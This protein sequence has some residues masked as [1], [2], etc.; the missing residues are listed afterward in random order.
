MFI[1]LYS[2]A[3]LYNKSSEGVNRFCC[4]SS[5][6]GRNPPSKASA[7]D[8]L[9]PW[10]AT[11]TGSL[12]S[13]EAACWNQLPP[14]S[15]SLR[16]TCWWPPLYLQHLAWHKKSHHLLDRD[17]PHPRPPLHKKPEGYPWV[18]HLGVGHEN[19][20]GLHVKICM[21]IAYTCIYF[22]MYLYVQVWTLYVHGL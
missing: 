7:C 22:H 9:L 16:E 2:T 5:I 10:A 12:L 17:C 18:L 3:C 8:I 4:S 14:G 6:L 20:I 15:P 13:N 19:L 11:G 1:Y 21:Y